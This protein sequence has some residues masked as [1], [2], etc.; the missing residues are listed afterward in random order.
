MSL[1]HEGS[2]TLEAGLLV[3]YVDGELDDAEEREVAR[4]LAACDACRGRAA[5]LEERSQHVSKTLQSADFTVPEGGERT[6]VRGVVSRP[7]SRQAGSRPGTVDRR[8]STT[9]LAACLALVFVG[10]AVVASAQIRSWMTAVWGGAPDA[11]EDAGVPAAAR[12]G[13]PEPGRAALEFRPAGPALDVVLGTIQ[14]GGVL[15]VRFAHGESATVSVAGGGTERLSVGGDGLRIDNAAGART[16]Y[17]LI[18]PAHVR[19]VSVGV[20]DREPVE[21][22]RTD[23]AGPLAVDLRQG[24]VVRTPPPHDDPRVDGA[25]GHAR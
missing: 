17:E 18:L 7:R 9:L 6:E 8:V 12:G 19:R 15:V 1:E 3:R 5:D 2:G 20:G 10:T 16:S 21:W 22:S 24:T 13:D 23:A 4:H 14:A 11:V 25:A